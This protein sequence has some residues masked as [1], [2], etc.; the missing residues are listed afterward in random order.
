MDHKTLFA[1]LFT[2]ALGSCA[3]TAPPPSPEDI[4]HAAA[5]ISA[6][7]LVTRI[8][9]RRIWAIARLS[10]KE[11]I[12]GRVVWVFGAMALVFLF[13]ENRV[14]VHALRHLHRDFHPLGFAVF[15]DDTFL[16]SDE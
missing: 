14:V 9:W 11:A 1:V 8:N 4:S 2:L 3:T 13:A 5:T 7:D 15:R 12:R 16:H 6:D 10:W